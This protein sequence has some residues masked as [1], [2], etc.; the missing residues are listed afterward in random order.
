[1]RVKEELVL[2]GSDGTQGYNTEEGEA[3][4]SDEAATE[5]RFAELFLGTSMENDEY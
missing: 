1:M 4:S 2:P 3:C 5:P